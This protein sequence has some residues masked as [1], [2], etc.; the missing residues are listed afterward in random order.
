MKTWE[1]VY[2][3]IVLGLFVLVVVSILLSEKGFKVVKT[4]YNK[5]TVTYIGKGK[6]LA[7][8]I[9]SWLGLFGLIWLIVKAATGGFSKKD[10]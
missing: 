4:I 10:N 6:S 5:T 7:Y 3:G 8:F 9:P 1:K 2:W